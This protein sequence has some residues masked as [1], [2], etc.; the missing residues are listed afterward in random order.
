MLRFLATMGR[1]KTAR[2]SRRTRSYGARSDQVAG[3][4]IKNMDTTAMQSARD[5]T[6]RVLQ[7]PEQAQQMAKRMSP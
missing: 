2:N 5:D 4:S 6:H 3:T 1:I 7:A